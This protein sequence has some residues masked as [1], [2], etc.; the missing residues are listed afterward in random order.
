MNDDLPQCFNQHTVSVQRGISWEIGSIHQERGSGLESEVKIRGVDE[1]RN[2]PQTVGLQSVAHSFTDSA[3][4][5]SHTRHEV[6][7]P[8]EG[9]VE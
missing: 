3:A 5:R 4:I 7:W 8:G 2:H 1:W 9:D 6:H